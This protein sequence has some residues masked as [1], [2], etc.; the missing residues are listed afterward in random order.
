MKVL[1]EKSVYLVLIA[2]VFSLAASVA[3][4]V[5]GAAKAV[6]SIVKL[7]S[8]DLK[9]PLAT[10]AFVKVM[11]IFLVATALLFFAVALYELFIRD[12]ALPG[13]L[14]VKNLYGLKVKLSSVVILIMAITFVERLIQ[15][16]NAQDTLYFGIAIAVVALALVA[17]TH[18]GT[19]D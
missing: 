19:E 18:F 10:I 11:D 1:L 15:W 9:D 5:W 3:V 14:E 17:L 16:E 6:D 8:T 2:V 7:A 12:L 4:Y 13:W